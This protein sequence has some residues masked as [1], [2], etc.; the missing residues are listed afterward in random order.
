MSA[1]PVVCLEFKIKNA[2][3][4][5][6]GCFASGEVIRRYGTGSHTFLLD[7]A[8]GKDVHMPGIF[9]LAFFF[10]STVFVHKSI[11]GQI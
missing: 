6:R 2:T 4:F 7:N 1:H 9:H 5:K 8:C 11:C 10:F 3:K